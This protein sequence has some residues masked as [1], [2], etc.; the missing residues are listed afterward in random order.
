[1][2]LDWFSHFRQR[3]GNLL[4]LSVHAQDCR[5]EHH[6]VRETAAMLLDGNTSESAPEPGA[7]RFHLRGQS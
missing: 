2:A 1:M 5:V 4:E 6:G 7:W 3:M